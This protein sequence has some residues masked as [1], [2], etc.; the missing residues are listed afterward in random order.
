[1]ARI[2]VIDDDK[3]IRT[4][5]EKFLS[6]DGHEVDL[7]ENGK[8]GLKLAELNQYDLIITDI[9]MP[10]KD[11]IEVISALNRTFTPARI[12]AMTG[13]ATKLDIGNLLAMAKALGADRVLS[14]PL[15]FIKL[16]AVAKEL[17]ETVK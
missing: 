4:L 13:G 16:Q 11:G 1:M 6:R 14:K 17:L 9:V 10:E 8:V 2:L 7:A 15:D 12:I 5:V 3:D